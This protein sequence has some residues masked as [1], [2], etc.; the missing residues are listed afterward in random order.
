MYKGNR[1][2]QTL[3]NWGI[4]FSNNTGFYD[5]TTTELMHLV[6][7]ELNLV[8]KNPDYINPYSKDE[9]QKKKMAEEQTKP[10]VK[11]PKKKKEVKKG[12]KIS[13]GRQEL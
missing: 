13:G 8:E 4:S 1:E 12:P 6:G 11:P 9:K 5:G 2:L 10:K 3:V 7:Q